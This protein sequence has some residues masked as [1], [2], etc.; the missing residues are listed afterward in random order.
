MSNIRPFRDEDRAAIV[1]IDNRDVPEHHQWT[2][3]EWIDEDALRSLDMVFRRAVIGHPKTDVPIGYL[4]ITDA[5]TSPR[6]R[7]GVCNIELM[8]AHDHRR[9]GLGQQLYA[10]A[11]EFAQ[12]RNAKR[13]TVWFMEHTPNEPGIAFCKNRGFTELDRATPSAL[14]LTDYDFSPFEASLM[15]PEANGYTMLAYADVPDNEENRHKLYA[16]AMPINR[17][18]PT[19]DTQDYTDP[20]F[21]EWKKRFLRPQWTPELQIIAAKDGEW[22]GLTKIGV[23]PE[24][25]RLGHTWSTGVL[26][27]HRGQGLATAMKV[28]VLQKAK[29]RGIL[30]VSTD[31]H[32]DNGPMLAIN[33]KLGFQADPAWVS[34]NKELTA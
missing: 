34:Y 13:L 22:V 26:K 24:K 20:P 3:Q 8:V 11:L 31:N 16:L 10:H 27:E 2:V 6:R 1:E 19:R 5:S 30:V 15:R 33:R 4:S 17:D 18:M 23:S 25:P 7:E 14:Y 12:E 21:E 9:Q 28:A 32:E 29:A